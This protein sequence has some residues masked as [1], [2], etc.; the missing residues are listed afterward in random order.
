M[1]LKAKH[2][3]QS[4]K[5]QLNIYGLHQCHF[6]QI[7]YLSHKLKFVGRFLFFRITRSCEGVN[8]RAWTYRWPKPHASNH[9]PRDQPEVPF[10]RLGVYTF[11]LQSQWSPLTPFHPSLDGFPRCVPEATLWEPYTHPLGIPR[12]LPVYF[13]WRYAIWKLS[14]A[15]PCIPWTSMSTDAEPV[16]GIVATF[17][18]VWNPFS[19]CFVVWQGL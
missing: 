15:F 2:K 4:Y 6:I 14:I 16:F 8:V 1:P 18:R 7:S 12:R 10:W 9:Y 13:W 3:W 17:W 5:L 11:P 19:V